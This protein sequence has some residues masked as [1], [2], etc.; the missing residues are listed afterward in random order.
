MRSLAE[1]RASIGMLAAL[2]A[3]SLG[4][5]AAVGVPAAE[6]SN[7]HPGMLERT[8]EGQ[9]RSQGFSTRRTESRWP[10]TTI[11]ATKGDCR[12]IV[13]DASRSD[14]QMVIYA[15]DAAQVGRLRYLFGG[16][17][18]R[19]PPTLRI[20]AGKIEARLLHGLRIGG[21]V[22]IAVALASSPQCGPGDFALG[23][24]RVV[25]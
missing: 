23:D 5:K 7:V 3:V 14:L 2:V 9:L 12:L 13:R 19:S 15:S 8:V 25:T 6:P 16:S 21:S 17:A 1:A 22:P 24:V 4:L 10:S 18:Y 20:L 11:F